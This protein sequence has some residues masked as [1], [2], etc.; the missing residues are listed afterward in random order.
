MKSAWVNTIVANDLDNDGDID[1]ITGNLGL[2]A[3]I[4]GT[5]DTPATL[6]AKDFDGNGK[7]DPIICFYKNGVSI[8]FATRDDLLMQIPSLASKFATYKSYAKVRSI[9]DIFSEDKLSDATISYAYEFQTCIIENLGN[10]KFKLN[11]LPP[12]AQLF[13]VFSILIDDFDEDGIK[14][15][16]LGGNLHRANINYGRYDAGLGLYLKEKGNLAFL[17]KTIQD[18][19]LIIKG[20][21]RDMKIIDTSAKKLIFISKSDARWQ[22]ININYNQSRTLI[23][24]D[25]Y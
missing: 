19:G 8:P 10:G 24:S 12:E 25:D 13:P 11:S 23:P 5:H 18:A 6:Y 4:K 16:L 7:I 1:F 14:D 21:V 2:N 9:E 20:E 22:V 17:P 15:I 3:K